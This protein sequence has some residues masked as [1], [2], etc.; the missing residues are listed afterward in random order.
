MTIKEMSNIKSYLYLA[1]KFDNASRVDRIVFN[2]FSAS[3]SQQ[4]FFFINE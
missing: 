2:Y 1:N 3:D 4:E